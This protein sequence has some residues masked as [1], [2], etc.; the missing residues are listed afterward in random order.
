MAPETGRPRSVVVVQ[1]VVPDYRMPFIDQLGERLGDRLLLVSGDEDWTHDVRHSDHAP[2]SLVQ[3]RYFAGRQLL[4]QSGALRPAFEADVAVVSLNPRIVSNWIVLGTR[5]IRRRRT[6]VWGHAWPRKGP[7]SRTDR[8]RDIMRRLADAVIVYTDR[9]AWDLRARRPK[10]D[11]TAAP[12]ALYR[13][14]EM[15]PADTGHPTDFLY[16]GRLNSSKK[17]GLL[18]EA[19][20]LA[21]P[22]MPE[23]VRLVFI[24]AGPLRN[25][26]AE[27]VA[28]LGLESRVLLL[29]HVSDVAEL[30]QAYSS[31][32]AS[33]SPGYVGLS[34]IQSLGN[35]VPMLIARD[36]PHA[37]E[38]EAIVEGE[39]GWF[40][41]SD[42][43]EALASLLAAITA[44][45]TSWTSRRAQ[46]AE[47]ARATYS[48]ERMV[49]AFVAA[50]RLVD[51]E[52]TSRDPAPGDEGS[53]S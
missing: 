50:L 47:R 5:R 28:A 13:M 23:D 29:G 9:E 1:T 48:V 51:H 2:V 22:S 46:I 20:H 6:L 18:L 26:L 34:L 4:W 7:R 24:G 41:D 40:F 21:S 17:P 45:R 25:D 42:S 12:N 38:I 31:A 27:R 32:I 8:V 11:V 3:N 52:V 43:S 37:P 35:G 39:N 19:F 15:V 33:V 16:V 44:Q 10:L 14:D 49:D 53:N 36:E 30:R